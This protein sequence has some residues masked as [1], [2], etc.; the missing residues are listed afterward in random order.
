M[1]RHMSQRHQRFYCEK[2]GLLSN[3][4]HAFPQASLV[5]H[6]VWL[7]M[8]LT[9][10]PLL[11]L[12]HSLVCVTLKQNGF[13][14]KAVSFFD[15]LVP[16]NSFRQWRR[17][18]KTHKILS[19]LFCDHIVPHNLTWSTTLDLASP[20]FPPSFYRFLTAQMWSE[21]VQLFHNLKYLL[22]ENWHRSISLK[23]WVKQNKRQTKKRLNI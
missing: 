22:T 8:K 18:M 1:P 9:R 6:T 15:I 14:L 23:K 7:K 4:S 10:S 5:N 20:V 13:V 11:W 21:V 2:L 3:T 19:G 12:T 17:G 16:K